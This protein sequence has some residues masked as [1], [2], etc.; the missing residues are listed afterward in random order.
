MMD[1][2]AFKLL[3]MVTY[4]SAS[5]PGAFGCCVSKGAGRLTRTMSKLGK[6]TSGSSSEKPHITQAKAAREDKSVFNRLDREKKQTFLDHGRNC[7][8]TGPAGSV[9]RLYSET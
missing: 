6:A 5:F 2:S 3:Q 8:A 9:P 1:H 7:S 4:I